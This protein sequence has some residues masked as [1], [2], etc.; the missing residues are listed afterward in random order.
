MKKFLSLLIIICV[1]IL[2]FSF[3]VYADESSNNEIISN[4]QMLD[5]EEDGLI[6]AFTFYSELDSKTY[7][8]KTYTDHVDVYNNEDE[9]LFNSLLVSS[10]TSEVN[11][12]NINSF[13]S[14]VPRLGPDDYDLWGNWV[15]YRT[16][17]MHIGDLTGWTISTLA[18]ALTGVFGLFL[19]PLTG[20]ATIIYNRQYESVYAEIYIST[21]TYC[22]ILVK[23]KYEFYDSSTDAFVKTEEKSPSWW[24]SAYD[25]SQPAACRV[26]AQKY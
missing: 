6:N 18:G 17:E 23:E 2:S 1:S 12:N 9:S 15:Y 14:A 11:Y 25:Y 8:V 5:L 22:P 7:L 20:L 13:N 19:G 10:E 3:P 26:L 21:N 4:I 16:D 24:G